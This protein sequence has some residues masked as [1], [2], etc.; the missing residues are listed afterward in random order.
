[1]ARFY[2]AA[3]RCF[4][5][6]DL[7]RPVCNY[8][9]GVAASIRHDKYVKWVDAEQMH[10]TLVFAGDA[11]D[12]VGDGLRR[13]LAEIDVPP[14]S[15]HL[16]GIEHVPPRGAPRVIWARLGGDLEA[17]VALQQEVE[18]IAGRH[19]VER[20]P[21]GFQPHVTLGRVKSP[22]GALALIDELRQVGST[23]RDK[24]FAPTALVLYRSELRPGGPVYTPLLRRP[25]P[26]PRG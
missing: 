24:P 26:A 15:L 10:L 8:L 19:G 14:L 20:D 25:A 16:A 13:D 7:P 21:R 12:T 2:H 22:F 17:L 3:V 11:D 9:A 6:L 5:A 1:M 4:V 23:L 18:A